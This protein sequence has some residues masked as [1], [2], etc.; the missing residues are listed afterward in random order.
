MGSVLMDNKT[1]KIRVVHV[2]TCL[3][4]GGAEMMLY[5]LLAHTD[6][7]RFEPVVI[8]LDGEAELGGRIMAHGIPVHCLNMKRSISSSWH[9]LKLTQLLRK[10]APDLIQGWMYHGNLAATLANRLLGGQR[11]ILWNIRQGVYD[12]QQESFMT[13]HIIQWGAH[14]SKKPSRIIYNAY[15]SAMQHEAMGYTEARTLVIPNGF[16][17]HLF[18]PTPYHRYSVRQELGIPADAIVIGMTARYHPIK[19]HALFIAA[20][21]L[22]H[23]HRKEVH[24]ILAGREVTPDNPELAAQRSRFGLDNNLHLLGERR[25]IPAILNAMDIFSLT[26]DGEAFPNVVGEAM[27]CGIPCITSDVGDI[28]LIIGNTGKV[29][30]DITPSALAFAWLEWINAGSAWRQEQGKQALQRI[31]KHYDI[32]NIAEQYQNTYKE[33]VNHV[34]TDGLLLPLKQTQFGRHAKQSA[35]DDFHTRTQ[36]AG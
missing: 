21:N 22:I 5:K 36:G 28:A 16:D 23:K 6:L 24:F 33:L 8:S 35:P 15:T 19:N 11:P 32:A 20:A 7:N 34:R 14:L 4:T 12:L 17:T 18:R 3:S 29:I 13:R 27:A 1:N 31:R 2:I 9:I 10:L 30:K 25:D 26:S